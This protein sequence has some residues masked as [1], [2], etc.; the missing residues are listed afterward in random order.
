MGWYLTNP[1]D[2]L[3]KAPLVYQI[4]LHGQNSSQSVTKAPERKKRNFAQYQKLI[5]SNE[6]SSYFYSADTISF[7]NN[8]LYLQFFRKIFLRNVESFPCFSNSRSANILTSVKIVNF[9]IFTN[10]VLILRI[11]LTLTYFQL[12]ALTIAVNLSVLREAPPIRPPSTL[13]FERSSAAL[14]S[15]IEPPY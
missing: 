14:A 4:M 3:F 1:C 13:T 11:Y 8:A 6:S 5:I 2:R 10:S 7:Y 15:F 12:A 9:N